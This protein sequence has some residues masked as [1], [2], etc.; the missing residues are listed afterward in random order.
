MNK[1]ETKQKITE[2]LNAGMSKT[3]AFQQ[4]SGG[5]LKS[6]ELAYHI[7][8]HLS[9]NLYGEHD[10]KIDTLITIMFVLAIFAAL[11]GWGI[12]AATGSTASWFIAGMAAL[13]QL[14]FAYGFYK[15]Y[16]PTYNIYIALTIIQLPKNLSGLTST[17]IATTIGLLIGL[18]TLGYVWY[19][20]SLL[21]PDFVFM[22]PKKIKG[23]YV[24]SN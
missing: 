2:L 7:A 10:K 22:R 19:V 13:I 1:K 18:A 3:E 15:N 17:P 21:F 14:L 11:V 12:G 5:A 9:T 6:N 24:F 8:S 20:R 23:Q 4:F 16:A